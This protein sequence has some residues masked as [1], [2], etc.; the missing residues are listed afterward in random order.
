MIHTLY[1]SVPQD[2]LNERS[3]YWII[4]AF[5]FV[6]LFLFAVT[7]SMVGIRWRSFLPGVE[8]SKGVVENLSS[9]IYTFM[10]HIT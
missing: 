4:F 8:D 1:P 7:A 9:A 6:I 2:R 10:S 5:A 3:S